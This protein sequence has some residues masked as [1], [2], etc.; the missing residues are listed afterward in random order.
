MAPLFLSGHRVAEITIEDVLYGLGL[1]C[2]P[3]EIGS[4]DGRGGRIEVDGQDDVGRPSM[5][6]CRLG[7]SESQASAS[8]E[9]VYETEFSLAKL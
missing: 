2:C 1:Y 5:L 8:S 6:A 7:D 4:I 3:W 9:E